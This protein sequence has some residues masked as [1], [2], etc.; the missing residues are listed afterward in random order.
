M[1]EILNL[2]TLASLREF[3]DPGE[4]TFLR[5][6]I[7]TYLEDT[8][9]RLQELRMALEKSTA[10]GMA[11]AAHAIKGSSLNVGAD[12]LADAAAAVERDG[13][14]GIVATSEA[15]AEAESLFKQVRLALLGYLG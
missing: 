8:E 2:E 4:T 15:I 9:V 12:C 3:E 10:D 7:T 5:D 13:K 14:R 11:K 1:A 6:I